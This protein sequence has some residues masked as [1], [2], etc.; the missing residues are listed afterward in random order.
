MVCTSTPHAEDPAF[1]SR[2]ERRVCKTLYLDKFPCAAA[3]RVLS[4]LFGLGEGI[5]SMDLHPA[6]GGNFS[7]SGIPVQVGLDNVGITK[8][9]NASETGLRY[10]PLYS[11]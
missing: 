4:K 10:R 9:T 8:L 2:Y 3:N 1:H 5:P 7:R 6:R 11:S